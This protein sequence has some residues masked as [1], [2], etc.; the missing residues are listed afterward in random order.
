LHA[1]CRTLRRALQENKS[2]AIRRCVFVLPLARMYPLLILYTRNSNRH[3]DIAGLSVH[4]DRRWAGGIS[5]VCDLCPEFLL[6]SD[7]LHNMRNYSMSKTIILPASPAGSELLA[8]VRTQPRT[9]V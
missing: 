8:A 9:A 7:I 1:E 3:H 4:P 5:Y 6:T 2:V